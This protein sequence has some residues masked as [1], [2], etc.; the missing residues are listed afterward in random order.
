MALKR[1]L[2]NQPNDGPMQPVTVCFALTPGHDP[3]PGRSHGPAMETR[4][5]TGEMK[6]VLHMGMHDMVFGDRYQHLALDDAPPFNI[7]RTI[8]T[9]L[10]M[11]TMI[12]AGAKVTFANGERFCAQAAGIVWPTTTPVSVTVDRYGV[13]VTIELLGIHLLPNHDMVGVSILRFFQDQ[14][15]RDKLR[16]LISK[17][18]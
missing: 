15:G 14:F 10:P 4:G 1:F 18:K 8:E 17:V 9:E 12:S 2:S 7:P 13:R 11:N 3:Q 16:D 6:G 5:W